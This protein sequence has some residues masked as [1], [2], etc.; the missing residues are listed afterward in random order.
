MLA[1]H[2]RTKHDKKLLSKY[3]LSVIMKRHNVLPALLFLYVVLN[4][5]AIH[6]GIWNAISVESYVAWIAS[7]IPSI[8]GTVA[9][10]KEPG[11]AAFILATSWSLIPI[12]YLLLLC[13]AKWQEVP[14]IWP[15][16]AQTVLMTIFAIIFAPLIVLFFFYCAPDPSSVGHF[17]RFG[18]VITRI[19]ES[20]YFMILY[21]S[22]IWLLAS[23]VLFFV[24]CEIY[25]CYTKIRNKL[26]YAK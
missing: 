5:V 23:S 22:G 10:S 2:D 9:I 25:V 11:S 17:D 12:A 15:K 18:F 21:G 20:R 7:I 1:D 6:F 19:K 3:L 13:V 24:T 4:L 14:K 26:A 16:N 8:N